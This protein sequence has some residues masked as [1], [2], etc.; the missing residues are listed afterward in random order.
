MAV[1]SSH[2]KD[3]ADFLPSNALLA[4]RNHGAVKIEMGGERLVKELP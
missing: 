1:V 2:G 3:L 4:D